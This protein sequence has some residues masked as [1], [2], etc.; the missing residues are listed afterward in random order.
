MKHTRGT[1]FTYICLSTS[2]THG[3][4]TSNQMKEDSFQL[5][6]NVYTRDQQAFEEPLEYESQLAKGM[7]KGRVR[8]KGMQWA[9]WSGV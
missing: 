5:P 7:G 8:W 9:R 3:H 4:K 2:L 1:P 6:T